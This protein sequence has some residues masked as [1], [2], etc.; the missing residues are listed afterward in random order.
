M[1]ENELIKTNAI[2]ENLI[3]KNINN[4]NDPKMES[5]DVNVNLNLDVINKDK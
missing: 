4:E 1:I 5:I 3:Y 2:I